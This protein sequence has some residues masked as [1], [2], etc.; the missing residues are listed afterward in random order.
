MLGMIRAYDEARFAPNQKILLALDE[1]GRTPIP[2][3]PDYIA[4]IAGRGMSALLYV[5][6]LS[7]LGEVYGDKGAETI[8]DNCRTQIYYPTPN[9]KTQEYV[10]RL[11][12]IRWYEDVTTSSGTSSGLTQ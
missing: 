9:V 11:A 3:L 6:S 4:T 10:S 8:L 12:G 7:Q 1:A 5:Q 2:K